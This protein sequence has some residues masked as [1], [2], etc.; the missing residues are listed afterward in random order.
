M[1]PRIRDLEFHPHRDPP[2]RDD[3]RR[4][5]EEIEIKP[6]LARAHT[7]V[8]LSAAFSLEHLGKIAA[9]LTPQFTETPE[10]FVRQTNQGNVRNVRR[11]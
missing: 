9:A 11:A 8:K 4:Q 6:E 7:I 10:S 3:R 2:G 5:Y 1:W